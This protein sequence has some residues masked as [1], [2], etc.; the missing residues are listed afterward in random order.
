MHVAYNLPDVLPRRRLEIVGTRGQLTATDTMGQTAGGRLEFLSA[1]EGWS[2]PV[3]F[4]AAVSPF[5]QQV[6]AFSAGLQDAVGPHLGAAWSYPLERDLALHRLLFDA[7]RL[8][9]PASQKEL[10]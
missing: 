6:S 10:T 1:R 2:G 7:A 8:A 4:D 5:E 3:E 9:R